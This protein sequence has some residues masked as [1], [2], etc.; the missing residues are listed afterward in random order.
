V[1]FPLV[2]GLPGRA[3]EQNV[4]NHGA[5]EAAPEL[6]ME[7]GHDSQRVSLPRADTGLIVPTLETIVVRMSQAAIQNHT[8]RRPYTV[9]REY[10]LFGQKRDKTRSRVTADVTFRPPG[11]K[12]YRIQGT[13]GSIIGEGI[14]RSVL[15][16]EATLAKDGGSSDISR[17]NYNFRFLREEVANG[18]LC[19]VLQL[20]PTRPKDKNLLRGTIWVDADTYLIRRTEG[21]P[22]K[23]TP[24][25]GCGTCTLCSS[26]RTSAECGCRPP[27]NSQP[28]YGCSAPRRCSRTTWDIATPSLPRQRT[29]RANSDTR[30]C[31]TRSRPLVCV[32][33]HN[34]S[35]I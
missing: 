25:G 24:R 34:R 22:Q 4:E 23:K 27:P 8:H 28:G 17:D 32:R 30:Q 35:C 18:R 10:Q 20:L 29:A 13:E 19:Y 12:R 31:M 14:V 6:R 3:Q 7:H 16:R 5:S 26:T 11:L 1:A 2:A 15:E 9:T 33:K 21:E